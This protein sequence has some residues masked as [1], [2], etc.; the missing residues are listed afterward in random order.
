MLKL[1]LGGSGS[2]K[3]TQLSDLI[4]ASAPHLPHIIL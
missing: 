3:H 2:G 4:Q 1:V